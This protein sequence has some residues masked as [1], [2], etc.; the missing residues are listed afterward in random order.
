MSSEP[1]PKVGYIYTPPLNS[2]NY[3]SGIIEWVGYP[4]FNFDNVKN[5][6]FKVAYIKE[7]IIQTSGLETVFH[8]VYVMNTDELAMSQTG[9]IIP[10]G[11]KN[12][13]MYTDEEFATL[14]AIQKVVNLQD[15]MIP[16]SYSADPGD[17]DFIASPCPSTIIGFGQLSLALEMLPAFQPPAVAPQ[18]YGGPALLLTTLI[19]LPMFITMPNV[20]E[21][22]CD[23]HIGARHVYLHKPRLGGPKL[24]LLLFTT[25][26]SAVCTCLSHNP[27]PT[28]VR[29]FPHFPALCARIPAALSMFLQLILR[30]SRTYST[31]GTTSN[32]F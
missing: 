6:F 3:V 10:D 13:C 31:V 29:T 16:L 5:S 32:V 26:L 24:S 22:R 30:Y 18:T 8:L 2:N 9:F 21:G 28:L 7:D 15:A 17:K 1:R 19:L 11:W 25:P 20:V 27:C 4:Q 23:N 14:P 12:M